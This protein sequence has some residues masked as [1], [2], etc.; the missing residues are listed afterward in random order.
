MWLF[1]HILV[2]G[3]ILHEVCLHEVI[4]INLKLK[5]NSEFLRHFKEIY[6]FSAVQTSMRLAHPQSQKK[7]KKQLYLFPPCNS[8]NVDL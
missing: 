1:F 7:K 8:G 3:N 2:L 5:R 4:C 6:T